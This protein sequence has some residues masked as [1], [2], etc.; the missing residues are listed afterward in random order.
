MDGIRVQG[1][2]GTPCRAPQ[3]PQST[4]ARQLARG[5]GQVD[6]AA[7]IGRDFTEPDYEYVWADGIHTNIG[8][9]PGHRG[10]VMPGVRAW[11]GRAVRPVSR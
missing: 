2:L 5:P 8:D 1:G 7:L 6:H 9:E 11:V 10:F 3:L 4:S